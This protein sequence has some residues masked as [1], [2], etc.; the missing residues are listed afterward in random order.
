MLRYS[1]LV[2]KASAFDE[3]EDESLPLVSSASMLSRSS[4]PFEHFEHVLETPAHETGVVL[5]NVKLAEDRVPSYACVTHAAIK[6]TEWFGPYTTW[7]RNLGALISFLMDYCLKVAG[8]GSFGPVVKLQAET[9]VKSW[10]TQRRRWI[11]G[12]AAV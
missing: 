10:I 3:E 12:A 6:K 7:V 1:A 9:D 5:E 4:T 2:G 8:F 11:N